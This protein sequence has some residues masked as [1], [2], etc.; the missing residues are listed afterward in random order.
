MSE[1]EGHYHG[2]DPFSSRP[3]GCRVDLI[4][5]LGRWGDKTRVDHARRSIALN[6]VGLFRLFRQLARYGLGSNGDRSIIRRKSC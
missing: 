2:T 5:L 3:E 6:A 1:L 4:E